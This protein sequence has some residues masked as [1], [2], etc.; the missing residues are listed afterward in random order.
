MLVGGCSDSTDGS[1]IEPVVEL[2]AALPE[3]TTGVFQLDNTD[4]ADG[5]VGAAADSATDPWRHNPHDLVDYY[6]SGMDLA[7]L[8]EQLLLA[9]VSRDGDRYALLASVASDTLD[10]LLSQEPTEDGGSY[11]G[12]PLEV[13]TATGLYLARPD[14]RTLVIGDLASV[15]QII[16]VLLGR[17]ADIGQAVI[18]DYL[19]PLREGQPYSFVYALPGMFSET[20]VPGKGN[21]SLNRATVA[22]AAYSLQ[23]DSVA[24]TARIVTPNA[25]VYTE[26]FLGLL[27]EGSPGSFEAVDDTIL[28]QLD[29]LSASRDI[30]GLVKSMFINM[31]A[32]DYAENVEQGQ[33]PPWLNFDVGSDPNSIFINFEFRD[34]ASRDAFEQE[35]LPEGFTLAP[36]RILDSDEPR[37]FLV[38]NI[39]QS[40]GGLV[41]G[42]RAEWSVFINDP[43]SGVP[44]FLVIQAAAENLTVDSVN[45]VV[46]PEPVSHDLSADAIESYVGVVDEETGEE[47]LYFSSRINWP[48]SPQ[49]NVR[50]AR[51][52]VAANDYIFWGNAVAD[53][54][55]YN[56]TVHNRPAALIT[57]D[58]ISF[59]DRSRWAAFI[60]PEP[61]HTVVYVNPLEIVISPWWNLDADY[62][63][64]TEAYRQ[65]LISFKNGF[66]P[67]TVLGIAEQAMLG[68]RAALTTATA[69]DAAPT[70]YYHFVIEDPPGLLDRIG[71]TGRYDPAPVSLYEESAADHYLT[72]TAYESAEDPCDTRA[73]WSIYVYNEAG[74]VSTLQIESL[75]DEACVDPVSLLGIPAA[76]GQL[77]G[78]DNTLQTNV[79]TPQLD[80]EAL[81]DLDNSSERQ[82][83]QD[84]IEATDEVCALNGTCTYSFY[85][86]NT[87]IEN[88]Q[89][90]DFGGIDVRGSTPWDDFID[91]EPAEVM[92]R[93]Y[94][95]IRALNPWRNVAP[96]GV[97]QAKR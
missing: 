31:N 44:R 48:Q 85:D 41:E 15:Q 93:G 47:S 51:Q 27:P 2:L 24:G 63:D 9:Q 62:L 83:S 92:V 53:R 36:L 68:N 72:L 70:A 16:E 77:Q 64:V 13:I 6:S 1:A 39:Y 40:S 18:G 3:T 45:L 73:D 75:S 91:T 35:H 4:E 26:R 54:G 78:A 97:D 28:I 89:R 33:N 52:F 11:E 57:G 60:K 21:S 59:I 79:A 88:V 74:R 38:L 17:A 58:E 46:P 61:V 76:I 96:L 37:Y 42:A 30:P 43:E 55:L 56:G 95:A 5:I 22:S 29:G 25:E 67:M 32:V 19:A 84:W 80:I 10:A 87:L 65:E 34:G 20:P 50:F 12:Y 8:G 14:S 90:I 94:P 86:G 23:G 71:A 81:I 66:Y 49:V 69:G 82:P 7:G